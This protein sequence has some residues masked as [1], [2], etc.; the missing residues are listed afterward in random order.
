M[1]VEGL[2]TDSEQL[3]VFVSDHQEWPQVV[4]PIPQEGEDGERRD[5]VMA[6]WQNDAMED[7]GFGCAIEFCRFNEFVRN[8]RDGLAEQED[9]ECADH[10]RKHERRVGVLQTPVGEHF[11]LRNDGHCP[12]N[13][14]GAHNDAEKQVATTES[15]F[16]EHVTKHCTCVDCNTG[17]QYCY[18][19]R[20]CEQ[21][22]EIELFLDAHIIVNR[23]W[24]RE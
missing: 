17:F 5:G 15:H 24:L 1:S 23:G 22:Q 3:L 12:R 14:H 19:Q 6:H 20:V 18:D 16:R 8:S 10:A 7:S 2:Q 4:F 9:T 21:S 13:H 11:V